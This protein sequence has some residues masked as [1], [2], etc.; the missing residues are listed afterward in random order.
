M[1]NRDLIRIKVVQ[2]AYAYSQNGECSVTK[3][4]NDA[5]ASPFDETVPYDEAG[6][7]EAESTASVF[8]SRVSIIVIVGLTVLIV[9]GVTVGIV[10]KKRKVGEKAE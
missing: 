8:S 3:A 7:E 5:S 10:Y 6:K 2:L 4:D 9:V 1:I